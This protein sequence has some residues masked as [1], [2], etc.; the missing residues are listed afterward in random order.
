MDLARAKTSDGHGTGA[1]YDT[2][3]TVFVGNLPFDVEEEDVIQALQSK[4][5]THFMFCCVVI[6]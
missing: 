2:T 5:D 6:H 3:R 4:G 1:L